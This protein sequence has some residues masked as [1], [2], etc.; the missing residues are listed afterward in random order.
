[1]KDLEDLIKTNRPKLAASS[2]KT[3]TNCLKNLFV[4]VFPKTEFNYKLFFVDYKKVLAYL[5]DVKFNVRK[6]I[7]SALVVISQN[8]KEEV[9][10]AY[11]SQMMEDSGKY[12]T[13]E[14]QHT[15][16]DTMKANWLDWPIIVDTLTKLKNQVY[17]I[18]KEAKPTKEH[19]L[20]LQKYIILA[21]Y[22]LIE[23]RRSQDYTQ[24]K[25][26]NYDEKTDNYYKKGTFYYQNYKTAKT[27]GLQSIKCPNDLK[28]LI[29]QWVKLNDKSDYLFTDY[30]DKPLTSSLMSKTLNSIFKKNVSVNILR[31]SYLTH[32]AGPELKKL[33]EIAKNMGHSMDEQALYIKN[34]PI[35][36]K[37]TD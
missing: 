3:Y 34:V 29:N 5:K 32:T 1:M 14:K 16:S 15:L 18:F 25:I 30:Y 6:T 33:Q 7:L 35:K 4:S 23:P 8:E 13:L 21:C 19:L 22:T 27:Y 9:L 12:N 37:I 17:W 10:N 28:Y 31:H 26:R 11:R 36:V 20:E 2:I 24:M